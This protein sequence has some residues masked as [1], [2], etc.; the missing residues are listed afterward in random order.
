MT[1]ILYH[2]EYFLAKRPAPVEFIINDRVFGTAVDN[3]S[4]VHTLKVV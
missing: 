4:F 1:K 2:L 3:N